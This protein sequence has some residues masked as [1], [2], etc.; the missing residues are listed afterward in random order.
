MANK[1]YNDYLPGTYDTAKIFLQADPTTGELGKVNLPT[2]VELNNAA[3]DYFLEMNHHI[4]QIDSAIKVRFFHYNGD[5]NGVLQMINGTAQI[6]QED[7]STGNYAYIIVR[8]DTSAMKVHLFTYNAA[9]DII[10][11]I[12]V[13]DGLITMQ[14]GGYNYANNAAAISAGLPVGAIY[15]N[16]DILQIVH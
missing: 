8:S 3:A 9:L 2:I 11:E 1:K 15:R 10:T 5:Y 16:G 14:Y 6:V 4:F 13:G 12:V 7:T